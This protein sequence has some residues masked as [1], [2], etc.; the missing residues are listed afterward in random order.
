[1][2]GKIVNSLNSI[3]PFSKKIIVSVSMIS[4]ALCLCGMGIILY[5]Y[6]NTMTVKLQAIASS[7]IYSSIVLFAQFVGISLVIDFFNAIIHNSDD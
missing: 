7:M 2:V 4:L 6:F 1:M 5:T 3:N